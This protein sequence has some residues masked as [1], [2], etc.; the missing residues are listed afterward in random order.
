MSLE[1]Y[2]FNV[3]QSSAS[4]S[5]STS[6]ASRQDLLTH[7]GSLQDTV[8]AVQSSLVRLEK[9]TREYTSGSG[10]P[11]CVHL[12]NKLNDAYAELKKRKS[13]KKL[14]QEINNLKKHV[15]DLE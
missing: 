15:H 12:K 13:E 1:K 14:F 3:I 7:L 4:S 9:K 10:C 5:T 6:T 8:A 11:N 2:G